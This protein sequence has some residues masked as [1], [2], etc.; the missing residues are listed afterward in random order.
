MSVQTQQRKAQNAAVYLP[1][2]DVF[3]QGFLKSNLL[4][5]GKDIEF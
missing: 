3:P 4:N 5:Y 1:D 2:P